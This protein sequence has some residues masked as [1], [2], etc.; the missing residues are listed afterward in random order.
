MAFSSIVM[1]NTYSSITINLLTFFLQ[2]GLD[3][4]EVLDKFHKTNAHTHTQTQN[5]IPNSYTRILANNLNF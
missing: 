3:K 4:D 5:E 1:H 2:L